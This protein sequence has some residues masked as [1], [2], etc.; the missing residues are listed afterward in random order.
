MD[1]TGSMIVCETL[2][3]IDLKYGYGV[4]RSDAGKMYHGPGM[5]LVRSLRKVSLPR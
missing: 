5:T 1:D 4:G 2:R 3:D